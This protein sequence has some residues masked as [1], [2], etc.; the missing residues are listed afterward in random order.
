MRSHNKPILKTLFYLWIFV[1]VSVY[2]EVPESYK[3]LMSK[4]NFKKDSYSFIVKNLT[5]PKEKAIIHNGNKNFN[6]ASLTKIITSFIALDELGPNYKWRSDFYY[7]GEIKDN[8]LQGDLIFFGRGDASFSIN[9]LEVLIRKIQKKG[10]K[11]IE[12]N[13]ILNKSY[14]GKLPDAI[15]FDDDPMRAYNVLPNAISIQSNTVNFKL[16]SQ[17]KKIKIEAKPDLKYLKIKN[18]IQVSE[19]NCVS[20]KQSL[21][22]Q[23]AKG[24]LGDM[25]I[26][27]GYFSKK[28][29]NKEID[30][31]VIDN[32]RYFYEVFKSLWAQNGGDFLGGY[33]VNDKERLESKLL[34]SH[35]SNALGVLIRDMN[36]YSLNLMSR[37]LILT[38]MAEDL[39]TQVTEDDV[40]QFILNWLINHGIDTNNIF[41]ENGAGLS[42]KTSINAESLM[43][44]MNKIYEH[45]YMPEMLSSFSILAEDGTLEKKMPFSK[46]K[47][48]GHFKTGSLKNVSA[49]AGY[50]V[51]KNKNKKILIFLMN[52]KAANKSYGLQNDLINIAFE[53]I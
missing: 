19:K 22:Y 38:V 41:V 7:T 47:K 26:F 10:I 13:L 16:I 25:I 53:S 11:K 9:D 8:T 5:N 34:E 12:G 45:P 44:I 1:S 46:V 15:D 2:A 18:N 43:K 27:Q 14:F 6:P 42:R 20:W 33:W 48:N 36:K 39:K 17:N 35:Y 23:K 4:Y 24:A 37:N 29:L 30:L 3:A 49:I 28:C 31:S 50:L 52:D 40:N 21:D 51:D 32:S